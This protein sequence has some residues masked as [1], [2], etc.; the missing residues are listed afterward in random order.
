VSANCCGAAFPQS[1]HLR[2]HFGQLLA[3]K[4]RQSRPAAAGRAWFLTVRSLRAASA[5]WR[6]RQS[7][8]IQRHSSMR[9]DWGAGLAKIY[10][11]HNS[12]L[13]WSPAREPIRPRPV[14]YGH[15][16]GNQRLV[17][18]ERFFQVLDCIGDS[19]AHR[20][21]AQ[22]RGGV[23]QPQLGFDCPLVLA[24]VSQFL[25]GAQNTRDERAAALTLF[26]KSLKYGLPDWLTITCFDIGFA[27]RF[28]ALELKRA[29]V[30]SG[31]EGADF[32]SAQKS[33]AMVL[34][35]VLGAFPRYYSS[36]FEA[37]V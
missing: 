12:E 36:V 29:L 35:A 13:C 30:D 14:R 34:E 15:E 10:R 17:Y 25:F 11:Q 5:N 37:L 4:P 7:K 18:L 2:V 16:Q 32:V 24:A 1:S 22:Y 21:H 33:H 3:V 19:Q 28:L 8:A 9:P 23:I 26:Q 6:Q 27:D 31:Y 20:E